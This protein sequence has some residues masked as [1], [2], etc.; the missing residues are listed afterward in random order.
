[1]R[2]KI[3]G[4]L[5]R[6]KGQG[7]FTLIELIIVIAI[8]GF[9]VAMIAP[10]L[11]NVASG[12]G[13]AICDTNQQRLRQV[14]AAYVE[15]KG[16]LPSRLT[17]LVTETA[18]GYEKPSVDDNNKDTGKEA[19]SRDMDNMV[20]L[21]LHALTAEEATELV[22]LGITE[23]YNLNLSTAVDP[24]YHGTESS[25][26]Y[27]RKVAVEAGVNVLMVG[28][29]HDGS[30]WDFS[31]LEENDT[32]GNPDLVYRIVLGVGPDSDLVREGQIQSAALCP[33]GMKRGDHFLYNNY[34]V[35]VPRLQATV[36]RLATGDVGGITV[37]HENGEVKEYDLTEAQE[38]WQFTTF[39]PEGCQLMGND[40]PQAWTITAVST[41]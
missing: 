21:H 38:A 4:L 22:D 11:A 23:V 30:S 37:T 18:A 14:L 41:L 16:Q 9:L 15:S 34:N 6:V 10:R 1:M 26:P 8:M 31:D 28:A 3:K 5:Q 29:G 7:G 36:D 35:I 40:D 19:L 32:F 12:S 24:D 25:Q 13:D 33:N 27:M 20:H 39:C 2:K 17:N